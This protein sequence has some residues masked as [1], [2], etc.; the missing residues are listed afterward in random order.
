M[1]L[2]VTAAL[3]LGSVGP[4]E[5][6]V[7]TFY[8]HV[9]ERRPLGVPAD[10]DRRSLW[11]LLSK[12]LADRLDELQACEDDYLSRLK[13]VRDAHD[14]KP[15]IPW[16]ESGLFS[17]DSE[18]A[19]PGEIKVL[20][21]HSAGAGL[22]EVGVELTYRD[23]FATYGRMPTDDNTFRW[24]VTVVVVREACRYVIDDVL[25]LNTDDGST[26]LRLATAYPECKSRRWVGTFP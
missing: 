1:M 20:T 13:Y 15:N 18:R 9:I 11:P 21:T 12:R 26:P 4:A 24:P 5:Q 3:L 8:A 25:H 14:L 6:V 23:T 2:L 10:G 22:T 19:L 16:L 7:R 17:G